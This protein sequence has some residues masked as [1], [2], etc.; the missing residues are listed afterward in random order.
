MGGSLRDLLLG[1]LPK[2]IDLVVRG[3]PE[4]LA[5]ALADE[6][7]GD[8]VAL[9]QARGVKRVTLPRKRYGRLIIDLAPLSSGDDIADD[10]ARRDFTVNAL[11]LPVAAFT[12]PTALAAP[13]GQPLASLIDP[14]GGW[15]DLRARV[16]RMVEEHVFQHDPLR[17]LRAIRLSVSRQLAIEPITAGILSRDAPLLRLV[18]PERLRDEL[19]QMLAP[20]YIV[21]SAQALEEYG[22]LSS[23]FPDPPAPIC[24]ATQP[25]LPEPGTSRWRT[26]SA[27]AALLAAA[28]GQAV[29]L[30]LEQQFLA[31]LVRL[32]HRPAFKKRWKK[33]PARACTRAD[34]ILLAAL[35]A[36][37]APAA[38]ESAIAA[39]LK[40][41]TLGRQAT[42]FIVFL[43][44]QSGMPWQVEPRPNASIPWRSARY[45]FERFGERG[46]DLVAFC[47][48][49]Q[50]AA[51]QGTAPDDEWYAK[52]QVLL[53]L[54]E[55][56]YEERNALIPPVLLDGGV[57]IARLG[58]TGGPLIGSLLA[59]VRRA[60]LDGLI[61]TRTEALQF[62]SEQ[63]DI[64]DAVD[65]LSGR[66]SSRPGMVQKLPDL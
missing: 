43:L 3:D 15:H 48:G 52:A 47:L 55:G 12:S 42:A 58:L 2:D 51:L 16:L 66:P 54:I 60:Q 37:L 39:A 24:P 29:P 14:F 61:R 13:S 30:P 7:A 41:L 64:S 31:P 19:L 23:I 4:P 45:Y 21:V 18:A 28:Q 25:K 26:L 17:L 62:I 59:K 63:A 57:I 38:E 36:D 46:V 10:L 34:S 65:A 35:L 33:S 6:L 5:R 20:S 50:I 49:R 22:L 40:R 56:Y 27:M 32:S 11:A 53:H 8:Y 9:N 1:V 44:Q